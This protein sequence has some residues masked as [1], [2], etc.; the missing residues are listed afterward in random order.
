MTANA[1]I[2][3]MA[4]AADAAHARLRASVDAVQRRL[5]PQQL[6]DDAMSRARINSRQL[7]DRAGA[8]LSAHP[9]AIG[10]ALA[11]VALA[12]VARAKISNAEID[13]GDDLDGYTD[14]EDA[15]LP[16][17]EPGYAAIDV[18]DADGWDDDA[19]PARAT[20]LE[21]AGRN[22][23]LAIVAGLA[24]GVALGLLFPPSKAERRLLADVTGD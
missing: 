5:A 14:Y 24:A 16:T 9:L 6:M 11:A 15:P 8:Q 1:D 20:V 4:E 10:A 21:E 7:L 22:P 13:L 19:A 17:A 2:D 23:A 18:P 12:L 3:A